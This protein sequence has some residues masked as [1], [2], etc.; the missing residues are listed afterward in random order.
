MTTVTIPWHNDCCI[1]PTDKT[2]R[3]LLQGLGNG[4]RP[5]NKFIEINKFRIIQAELNDQDYEIFWDCMKLYDAYGINYFSA[6]LNLILGSYDSF[7]DGIE[8][9][10]RLP[11]HWCYHTDSEFLNLVNVLHFFCIQ[12]YQGISISDFDSAA[13]NIGSLYRNAITHKMNIR[14]A[15]SL[16]GVKQKVSHYFNFDN[17]SESDFGTLFHLFTQVNND[18]SISIDE[19]MVMAQQAPHQMYVTIFKKDNHILYI[20]KTTRLLQ[21]IGDVRKRT[22]ADS[23]RF[24]AIDP[25]YVDD[26]LIS[27]KILYDLP[28]NKIRPSVK[29][30]K[31]ATV[32][33]AIFAYKQAESIP[34]KKVLAAIERGR[35]RVIDLGNGQELIDKIELHRALFHIPTI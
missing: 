14:K 9:W 12:S 27:L 6:Y 13:A 29:N 18:H 33:Q 32:N 25:E 28:L 10:F 11:D 30:R 16:A 3:D 4:I 21:H 19:A 31:Y 35:L 23:V 1:I 5:N 20:S 15:K 22:N 8:S 17:Y 34:K 2:Y 24:T 26:L 7:S